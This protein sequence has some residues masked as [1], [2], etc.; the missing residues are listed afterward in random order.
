[1][2]KK[3]FFE[4]SRPFWDVTRLL[5]RDVKGTEHVPFR[6]AQL[7][8]LAFMFR[9]VPRKKIFCCSRDGTSFVPFCSAQKYIFFLIF[10]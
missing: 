6:S 3:Q 10:G 7:F 9:S 8:K 1:M 2:K 4:K 5:T